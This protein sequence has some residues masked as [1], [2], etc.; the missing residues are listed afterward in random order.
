[1]GHVRGDQLDAIRPWVARAAAAGD[2]VVFA[3]HHN[4]GSLGLPSRV[5]LREL[6][7]GLAHPLVYL[8][9]HTHRGFW[10]VHRALDRRP[11]LELNVSSLSDWPIAYRRIRVAYDAAA[12]R[13]RIDGDL[14]PAGD[15]PHASD[16]DLLAAWRTQ[17]CERAGFAPDYLRMVETGLVERQRGTR[18][19]LFAWLREELGGA[20]DDCELDRYVR[21]NAYQDEM[22][23][24]LIETGLHLGALAAPL[25]EGT[26]PAHCG[27]DGWFRCATRLLAETPTDLAGQR[28]LFRRK[29]ALVELLGDRLDDLD[30]PQ[31][32]A[33]MTCRA[34]QA[35]KVDFD[36]TPDER[37]VNRGEAKRRAEQFFRVEA[38]V[39]MQ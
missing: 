34:V 16:A 37:N 17:T 3:G 30:A 29:A 8:S 12:N 33:Y 28:A 25:G 13:L 19:G 26:L 36:E 18:G 32:K 24:A 27:A 23:L 4:W 6:M 38:S 35:A 5:L 31:A 2:I 7:R 20:C 9:A 39:G 14:M 15:R 22:L 21:A 10:A 1:V 11:L